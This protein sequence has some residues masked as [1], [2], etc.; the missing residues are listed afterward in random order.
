MLNESFRLSISQLTK[1]MEEILMEQDHNGRKKNVYYQMGKTS[2]EEVTASAVILAA[3]VHISEQFT[4]LSILRMG[5]EKGQRSLEQYKVN[6]NGNEIRVEVDHVLPEG[7]ALKLVKR[8]ER[9]PDTPI[10]TIIFTTSNLVNHWALPQSHSPSTLRT[11]TLR[12]VD[13]I[14]VVT[15]GTAVRRKVANLGEDERGSMIRKS[16]FSGSPPG[17]PSP[18]MRRASLMHQ[19]SGV[20][21]LHKSVR[22]FKGELSVGETIQLYVIEVS[23][24]SFTWRTY[25]RYREF[26]AFRQFILMELKDS[27]LISKLPPFPP[28]AMGKLRGKALED[29]KNALENFL[30]FLCSVGG[31]NALNVV[32]AL[33][34]FLEIPEHTEDVATV[35]KAQ[36]VLRQQMLGN[37]PSFDTKPELFPKHVLTAMLSRG[38]RVIKFGRQGKPKERIL[39]N[40]VD[41]ALAIL[42]WADEEE[43]IEHKAR[44]AIGIPQGARSL[45]LRNVREIRRGTDLD[46]SRSGYCGTANLRKYCEPIDY[47]YCISLI[48][49]DRTFDIQLMS[50]SDY[51]GFVPNL[52]KHHQ[53]LVQ[54][55]TGEFNEMYEEVAFRH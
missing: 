55:D 38:L 17:S 28:K 2:F 19:N 30:S 8:L 40:G 29:R 42:Y 51:D 20:V 43:L 10:E 21:A 1:P 32:D 23:S 34:S 9:V 14:Q 35:P 36:T 6:E 15:E 11:A 27:D 12:I 47:A 33:S 39:F 18:S 46:P 44:K 31:Y 25:S 45:L 48:F 16:S 49:V 54:Q 5:P 50:R 22:R 3:V 4:E 7:Q 13:V 24:N 26:E 37:L 53:S 52:I 41:D